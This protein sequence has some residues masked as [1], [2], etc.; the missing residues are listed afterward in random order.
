MISTYNVLNDLNTL[1]DAF[2]EPRIQDRF[3]LSEVQY[4]EGED[5][6]AIR[7]F[8]PGAS[9]EDIELQLENNVLKLTFNKKEPET[10]SRYTRRERSFGTYS[11][12]VKLPYRVDPEKIDAQLKD[13]VL[14][15]TL[16]KSEDARP[17]KIEVK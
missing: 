6:L 9:Q 11:K 12:S 8:V 17:K 13:G 16:E 4:R 1:L 7:Y 5:S 3:E 10:K 15:V 14:T 2:V